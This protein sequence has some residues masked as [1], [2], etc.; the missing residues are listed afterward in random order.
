M[1]DL[2]VPLQLETRMAPFLGMLPQTGV[3]SCDERQP[4]LSEERLSLIC[5]VHT[6]KGEANLGS[7]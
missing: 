6:Q 5:F 1:K 7:F 3:I 2:S 4:A